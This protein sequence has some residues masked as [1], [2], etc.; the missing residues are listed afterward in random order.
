[1][2]NL[3][4]ATW[5]NMTYPISGY[6][7]FLHKDDQAG[8][9]CVYSSKGY[10]DGNAD[11][12][13]APSTWEKYTFSGNDLKLTPYQTLVNFTKA[14]ITRIAIFTLANINHIYYCPNQNGYT[15]ATIPTISAQTH[16]IGTP[17]QITYT[18]FKSNAPSTCTDDIIYMS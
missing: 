5:T 12:D 3:G 14:D 7:G 4:A 6:V 8:Y 11:V 10:N 1:M 16:Y 17:L 15:V 2:G 9:T 13:N 18:A